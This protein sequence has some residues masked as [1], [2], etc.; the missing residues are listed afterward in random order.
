[1]LDRNGC[2]AGYGRGYYKRD[3][4]SCFHGDRERTPIYHRAHRRHA[5]H[6]RSTFEAIMLKKIANQ[7][8]LDN[9]IPLGQ[10][11]DLQYARINY[12]EGIKGD[13]NEGFPD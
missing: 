2:N 8:S 5:W 13:V 9:K 4:D 6:I 1:M 12:Q 7:F 10:L 3:Y 11:T